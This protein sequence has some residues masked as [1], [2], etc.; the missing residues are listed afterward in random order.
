MCSPP[1]DSLIGRDAQTLIKLPRASCMLRLHCLPWIRIES[2]WIRAMADNN[3]NHS[4]NTSIKAFKKLSSRGG[5][6]AEGHERHALFPGT[7][8]RLSS[9]WRIIAENL[10]YRCTSMRSLV[11]SLNMTSRGQH[12]SRGVVNRKACDRQRGRDA[13][14]HL[15]D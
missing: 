10:V 9:G 13:A 1:I 12:S 4:T 8:P 3:G 14:R 2:E 7:E 5:S 15:R 6:A 11:I